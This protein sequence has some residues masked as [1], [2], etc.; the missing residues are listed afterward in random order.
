MI[1]SVAKQHRHQGIESNRTGW[2]YRIVRIE[3]DP[4]R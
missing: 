2:P 4:N 3:S 1:A